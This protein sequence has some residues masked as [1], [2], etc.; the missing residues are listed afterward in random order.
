[1]R[2][3]A[4]LFQF[5]G[6]LELSEDTS[7]TCVRQTV[8][9]GLDD[10][11]ARLLRATARPLVRRGMRRRVEAQLTRLKEMVELERAG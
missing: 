9:A 5:R 3:V 6:T 2:S 10:A 11:L 4:G 8:D 7:G 1:V